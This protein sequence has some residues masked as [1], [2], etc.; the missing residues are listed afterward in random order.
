[1]YVILITYIIKIV[2]RPTIFQLTQ[3][4]TGKKTN[5]TNN[6]PMPYATGVMN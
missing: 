1:M 5:K 3:Q 4:K 6:N 2:K